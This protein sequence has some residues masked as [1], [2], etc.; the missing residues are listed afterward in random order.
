LTLFIY[1]CYQ[2]GFLFNEKKKLKV[3]YPKEEMK[4]KNE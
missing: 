3:F 2:V 1:L 4:T